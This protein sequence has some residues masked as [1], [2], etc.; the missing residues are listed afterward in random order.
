MNKITTMTTALLASL[1]AST[2]NATTIDFEIK[3]IASNQGKIY[4]Q[5][6][7]GEESYK[8]G[9]AY[10]SS[11]IQAKPGKITVSFNDLDAGD[12]AVRFFHDQNDNGKLETN[13]FGLPTEG[14]GFSNDAKPNFGPLDYQDI[15]FTVSEN[16]ASITNGAAV[17]Y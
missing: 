4:V 11:I 1:F 9:K 14:Y 10:L 12:Y 17:I 8:K 13:L 2:V 7:K 5:L 6:F 15:Q 16:Q 3:G